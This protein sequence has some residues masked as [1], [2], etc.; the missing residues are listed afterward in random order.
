MKVSL[1]NNGLTSACGSV[2]TKIILLLSLL[3]ARRQEVPEQ[4]EKIMVL[5]IFVHRNQRQLARDG[6][7]RLFLHRDENM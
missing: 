4:L 2:D 1:M 5:L 7:P 6:W 3:S